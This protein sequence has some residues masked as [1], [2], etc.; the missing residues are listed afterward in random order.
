MG[1]DLRTDYRP[2]ATPRVVTIV[3][4]VLA[5]LAGAL[6]VIGILVVAVP[7]HVPRVGDGVSYTCSPIGGEDET[8][9][10]DCNGRVRGR[11]EAGAVAGLTGAVLGLAAFGVEAG[12]RRERSDS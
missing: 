4:V 2:E 11:L 7:V 10:N 6:L 12:I 9:A 5:L 3:P 8:I 1:A